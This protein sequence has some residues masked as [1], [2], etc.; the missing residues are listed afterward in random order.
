MD[1]WLAAALDYV[2]LWL[3]FQMRLSKMPGCII[4]IAQRDRIIHEHA[5]GFADIAKGEKLTP[6]HRFRVASHTK[7][8]TAAGI[9]KLREHRRLRLD[10]AVGQYV[11]GL[12]KEIAA[13][14]IAQV[15]SHSAGIGRDGLDAGYYSEKRPFPSAEELKQDLRLPPAIDANTRFK[16]SNQG[17]G[18]L[19]LLI[20][21]VTREPYRTWIKREIVDAAGLTETA[22]DM[23]L[24]RRAP[25]ARGHTAKLL[26]GQPLVIPGDYSLRALAP[27][28]GLVST[29]SDLALYFGQLAPGA[30]Q[31][32]LS[33]ASRREM[34]R[35]HWRNPH[36]SQEGYYGLGIISGALGGWEWFGHSGGLQ[37]Y[38]SRTCMLPRQELSISVLTNS[39]DGWAGY[40]LDGVMHILR[41]FSMRGAPSRRVRDWS[42]RWWSVWGALDLVAMGDTVVGANPHMGNPF[43]DATEIKVTGRDKGMI[44][45]ANGYQ[46]H[47]EPLRRL[48]D[49]SGRVAELW[50]SASRLQP[51]ARV[52]ADMRRRYGG[53]YT[54]K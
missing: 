40:M 16:Y 43:A 39:T 18:L 4:A 54:S 48:R 51:E 49:K 12:H 24:P 45:L 1:K 14:T 31:S 5:F 17:F 13:A 3:E 9:M 36:S 35:R 25:F 6:R 26:T 32:V 42:G 52:A 20:E 47:G 2:P 23:P 38:I 28:G 44:T 7:S 19:G 50:W 34:V 53:Q 22:P 10:D 41:T 8:F 29:A 11:S 21:A 33:A 15:M 46:N 37:G 27:A 30:K